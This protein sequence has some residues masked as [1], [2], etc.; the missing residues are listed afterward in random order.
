MT[1]TAA[2]AIFEVHRDRLF[3]V[4]Y[5]QDPN[6]PTIQTGS[7]GKV[8]GITANGADNVVVTG[9]D[10]LEGAVESYQPTVV[11]LSCVPV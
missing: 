8:D 10:G 5:R 4:G 9:A 11:S 2:D 6:D 3:G 1:T 7:P